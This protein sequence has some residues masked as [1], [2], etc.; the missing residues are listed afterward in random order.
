MSWEDELGHN[1]EYFFMTF[2]LM[3]SSRELKD[4]ERVQDEGSGLGIG[5]GMAEVY[6]V[7]RDST[8]LQKM[9]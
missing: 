6:G 9:C 5:T 2:L 4:W 8:M 1:R 7:M 3:F